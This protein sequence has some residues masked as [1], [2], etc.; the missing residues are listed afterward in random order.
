MTV[1]FHIS[2]IPIYADLLVSKDIHNSCWGMIGSLHKEP[3][4]I[5]TGRSYSSMGRKYCCIFESRVLLVSRVFTREQVVVH[6]RSKQAV[7]VTLVHA[8]LRTLTAD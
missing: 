4:G 2:G 7:Q 1:R 6:L 5:L 3:T 8:S